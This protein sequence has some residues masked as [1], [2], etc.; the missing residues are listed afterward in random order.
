MKT[1][2]L[3]LLFELRDNSQRYYRNYD[4]FWKEI[5]DLNFAELKHTQKYRIRDDIEFLINEQWRLHKHFTDIITEECGTSCE[6]YKAEQELPQ[7]E[8]EPQR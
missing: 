7:L 1:K 6:D 5:R 2:T 8:I 4:G 3:K